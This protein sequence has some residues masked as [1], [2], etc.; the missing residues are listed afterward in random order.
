M[1]FHAMELTNEITQ[2]KIGVAF[3]QHVGWDDEVL[4]TFGLGNRD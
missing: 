3:E 4:S 1:R 2:Y